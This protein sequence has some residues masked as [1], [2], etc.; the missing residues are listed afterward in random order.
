MRLAEL[1]PAQVELLRIAYAAFRDSA[2][3]PTLAYVDG[4]IARQDGLDIDDLLADMPA[5]VVRADGNYVS[6]SSLVE[7]TV[8]GLSLIEEARSDLDQ[9]VALV[10]RCADLE[11]SSKPDP[12]GGGT[13]AVSRS[14]V[15]PDADS[16]VPN[17]ALVRAFR[18][19]QMEGVNWGS[20]GPE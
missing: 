18:L 15:A 11:R 4:V 17:D 2:E 9:F 8:A 20:S 12:R 1:S 6:T 10:R 7:V 19:V 13:I 14:D 3:W 5:G 16:P